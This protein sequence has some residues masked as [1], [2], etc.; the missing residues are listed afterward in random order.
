M[1]GKRVSLY[2]RF[3]WSVVTPVLMIIIF[4]YSAISI[5]PLTYGRMNYP[6]EYI[7]KTLSVV[8]RFRNDQNSI[9]NLE[10]IFFFSAIGWSIFAFGVLQV[11]SSI[12]SVFLSFPK[13]YSVS[14]FPYGLSM[15]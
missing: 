9:L 13:L 10:S 5:E 11:C 4:V 15:K 14:S 6:G 2:W 7:G 8:G 1:S 12:Q 3:C